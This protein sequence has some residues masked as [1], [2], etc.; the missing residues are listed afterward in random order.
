M[1]NKI[2]PEKWDFYKQ[3]YMKWWD[4]LSQDEK[5]KAKDH[6]LKVRDWNFL[7]K[8]PFPNMWDITNI[9]VNKLSDKHIYRIW[10]FKDQII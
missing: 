6:F 9:R 8:N 3:Q 1:S 5:L 4:S 2:S 7:Q 10:V